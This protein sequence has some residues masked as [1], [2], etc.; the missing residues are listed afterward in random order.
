[1]P[2]VLML[3]FWTTGGGYDIWVSSDSTQ[4]ADL[5]SLYILDTLSRIANFCNIGIYQDDGI[6]SIPNCNGPLT[7]YTN[8]YTTPSEQ[9]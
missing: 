6:I 7:S 4:I 2:T 3:D 9:R 5:V 1:M 8:I